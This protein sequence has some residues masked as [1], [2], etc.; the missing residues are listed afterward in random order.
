MSPLGVM[1]T[2]LNISALNDIPAQIA[3]AMATGN[4]ARV[5]ELNTGIIQ[6][7]K[8]ADIVLLGVDPDLNHAKRLQSIEAGDMP[9][10]TK[11]IV[12]GE[13]IY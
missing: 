7:E 4:T 6:K 2:V 13:V 8:R 3:L 10:V 11:V 1:T 5:Y 12:D 9:V